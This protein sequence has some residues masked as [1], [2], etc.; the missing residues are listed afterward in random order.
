MLHAEDYGF[1]PRPNPLRGDETAE[2]VQ[3]K[4]DQ[5]NQ[6]S[7]PNGV[8]ANDET[9]D[10][11]GTEVLA[12]VEKFIRQYLAAP[13]VAYLPLAVYFIATHFADVFFS[14]PYIGVTSPTKGCGK[15]RI[16]E[17]ADL[18][19]AGAIQ[20]TAASVAALFRMLGNCATV[21]WDE[22]EAF[23]NKHR[24]ESTDLI[25]Q[26]LN[27]GYKR[28]AK[29]PRA[30]GPNH[31][32]NHYPV[33]GPKMFTAIG[34]LPETLADRSI[35]IHLQKRPRDKKLK[36]W[37]GQRVANDAAPIK[38][39]IE[40]WAQ[41]NLEDVR[42]AN[43]AID[44]LEFL[45]DREDEIWSPLFVLC[46]MLA[47]ERLNELKTCALMLVAKK[48]ADAVEDSLA[49][50]L[51][52]DLQ[53]VQPKIR[54]QELDERAGAEAVVA[55][56]ILVQ[57]LQA[58]DD[59]PWNVRDHELTTR[60]LARMLR[61]FDVEARPVR[62]GQ[63]SGYSRYFWRDLEDAFSRY[64]PTFD[65]KSSTSSTTR[66]NIDDSADLESSTEGQC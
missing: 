63:K 61:P 2:E 1:S 34:E 23:R 27:V 25:V 14:F 21:L 26:I 3:A 55:G 42:K 41:T 35:R 19:C 24:S 13:E 8:A 30:D 52:S 4:R 53:E 37:K 44:D 17:L 49:L 46:S 48:A 50:K 16:L 56:N 58:L 66:V 60:K 57:K 62:I 28:G 11:T 54:Q 40:Q 33:Y 36:R 20:I 45:A 64:L 39:A 18:F 65:Q 59:N 10:E 43:N 9:S 32:V 29:V 38:Q 12:K 51:L 6:P 7:R 47:P 31:T 15:T 5:I 22:C